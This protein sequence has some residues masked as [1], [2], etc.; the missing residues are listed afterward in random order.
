[1]IFCLRFL[2]LATALCAAVSAYAA[3]TSAEIRS[4]AGVNARREPVIDWTRSVVSRGFGTTEAN[5]NATD[6]ARLRLKEAEASY[7]YGDYARARALWTPLAEQGIADAQANLGWIA[8]RGLG[9]AIDLAQAMDWY[10][11]A[12]KQGHAIAQNN[13]GALY[14]HGLGVPQDDVQALAWYR[15][16]AASGYRYAQYNLAQFYLQ[17]RAI[18]K[19][20]RQARIWLERAAAQGV[21]AAQTELKAK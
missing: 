10:L 16:S 19:D 18:E 14:E 13:L 20:L 17:G 7:F 6:L 4:D 1:M 5:Q 2:V 3:E 11:L 12:A 21:A 8:Q 15:L 9:A